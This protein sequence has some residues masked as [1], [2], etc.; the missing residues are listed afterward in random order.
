MFLKAQA[1][2]DLTKKAAHYKELQKILVQEAASVFLQ[3]PANTTAIS[4]ELSGY[5]FYPVYVQDLST[6]YYIKQ[7]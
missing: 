2:M 4:K 1:E 7:Q 3:V 6:V 5:K